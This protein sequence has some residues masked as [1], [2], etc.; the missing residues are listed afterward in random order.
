MVEELWSTYLISQESNLNN[1][2][3]SLVKKIIALYESYDLDIIDMGED[4]FARL[5][6]YYLKNPK[7]LDNDLKKAKVINKL[8]KNLDEED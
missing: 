4:E 8:N 3:K 2:P 7:Q 1:F 6:N 5:C